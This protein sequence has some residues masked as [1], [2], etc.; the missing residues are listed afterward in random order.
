MPELREKP[1]SRS[2]WKE[3]AEDSDAVRL[4]QGFVRGGRPIEQA[5]S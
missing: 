3:V 5:W 4:E 1:G 2:F